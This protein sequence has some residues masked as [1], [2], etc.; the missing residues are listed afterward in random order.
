MI[1]QNSNNFFVYASD[2]DPYVNL[3]KEKSLAKHLAVEPQIIKGAG[4]FNIKAG[5]DTF[6]K[7]FEDIKALIG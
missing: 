7:L 3:E 2:N 4:H 6:F 1:K 5:Y